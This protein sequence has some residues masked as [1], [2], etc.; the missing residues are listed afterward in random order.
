[1]YLVQKFS[2]KIKSKCCK[3]LKKSQEDSVRILHP[4][5]WCSAMTTTLFYIS[6]RL[7][8]N[9]YALFTFPWVSPWQSLCEYSLKQNE[10]GVRKCKWTVSIVCSLEDILAFISELW[11]G[12]KIFLWNQKSVSKVMTRWNDSLNV[13]FSWFDGFSIWWGF[14]P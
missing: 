7:Y 4:M 14:S 2:V 6:N 5:Q 12:W 3:A 13:S 9:I 1:M 11:R 8:N 10:N